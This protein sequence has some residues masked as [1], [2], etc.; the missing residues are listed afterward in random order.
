MVSY[1]QQF[2]PSFTLANLQNALSSVNQLSPTDISSVIST[3][4]TDGLSSYLSQAITASQQTAVH[5]GYTPQRPAPPVR[6]LTPTSSEKAKRFPHIETAIYVP[7]QAHLLR[8]SCR[9]AG[10]VGLAVL[11]TGLTIAAA[12]S[13][14]ALAAAFWPAV[15]SACNY[16][17]AAITIG[18]ALVNC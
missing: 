13:G 7:G 4:Q 6:I 11:L 3:L 5:F 9:T 2:Q 14:G 16:G 17:G 8:V 18:S 1:I 10:L 12:V 15:V